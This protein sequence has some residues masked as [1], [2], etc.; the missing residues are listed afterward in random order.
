MH[1][2]DH[3]LAGA[4]P[5]YPTDDP[6]HDLGHIRRVIQSCR[7]LGA[8][9]NARLELLLPAAALHDLVNVPKNHPDRAR[10]SRLAADRA[11]PLLGDAGYTP[12]EI[13]AIAQAILEH[14]FSLGLKPTSLEAAVL[15]DADRLDALGAVGIMR[16]LSCGARMGASYY[17]VADPFARSRPLDDKAF[18]LDHFFVKLFLLPDLMNT[19]A[20]RAEA[21]RRVEFMRAF[22]RQL[23]S[24]IGTTP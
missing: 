11:R 20:G 1:R 17:D 8:Q 2:F 6:G 18:S 7:Q 16:C 15:Q 19:S 4:Q 24:E 21:L 13:A 5:L 9:E 23:G 22:L 10:A 3:V 12:A 14:S